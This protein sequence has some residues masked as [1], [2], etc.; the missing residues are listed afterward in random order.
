MGKYDIIAV[1]AFPRVLAQMPHKPCTAN[2][3]ALAPVR[4]TGGDT[5]HVL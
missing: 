1:G 4:H 2:S 3:V 5:K